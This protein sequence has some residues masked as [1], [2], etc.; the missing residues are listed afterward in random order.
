MNSEYEGHVRELMEKVESASRE[1]TIAINQ[2]TYGVT[3]I[4]GVVQSNAATAEQSSPSRE[5]LSAQAN[6]LREG[7]RKFKISVQKEHN[8]TSF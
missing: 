4:S 2:V 3:E 1:Q 7:V 8:K 6:L 5:E